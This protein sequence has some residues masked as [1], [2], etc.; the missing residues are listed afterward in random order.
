MIT[1]FTLHA[2]EKPLDRIDSV[3]SMPREVAALAKPAVLRGIVTYSEPIPRGAFVIEDESAGIYVS[4]NDPVWQGPQPSP[5]SLVE[6]TGVTGQGGY[7]PVLHARSLK[8]LGKAWMP[9]AQPVSVS[10]L[11]TGRFDSRRVEFRGVVRHAGHRKEMEKFWLEMTGEFGQLSV[12]AIE[13]GG[14][15]PEHLID[16][17][18]TVRG[19]C[20]PFFNERAQVAGVRLV[21]NSAREVEINRPPM[22]DPFEIPLVPLD[23]LQPFSPQG[24][25][26]HRQ[27]IE[28]TVTFVEPGSFL[29]LQEGENAVRV[30]LARHV[31][32]SIGDRV[33]AVG[34]PEVRKR[35]IE[36]HRA[37]VR[38]TG[39]AP[40][41][42]PIHIQRQDAVPDAPAG[43]PEKRRCLDGRL[44]S[45]DGR[46]ESV[47]LMRDGGMNLFLACDGKVVTAKVNP[48]PGAGPVDDLR[49]GSMVRAT[50]VCLVEYTV[51][52]P[53]RD[54]SN[55]YSMSLLIRNAGDVKVLSAASW[56]TSGRLRIALG[57]SAAVLVLAFA[58]VVALRREVTRKTAV[59]AV[60]MGA[61]RDAQVEF[62][63]TLRERERVA[64]D[65][66]DTV[67]QALTGSRNLSDV[68]A[69][70]AGQRHAGSGDPLHHRWHRSHA[71]HGRDLL[72]TH[73]HHFQHHA[74]GGRLRAGRRGKRGG[75]RVLSDRAEPH[76]RGRGIRG[77][78]R[79]TGHGP[80]ARKL[81]PLS[82]RRHYPQ[83]DRPLPGSGPQ[84][85]RSATDSNDTTDER[86][87][88][89]VHP[90][91][92]RSDR[93][94][95]LRG[96]GLDQER[97]TGGPRH[98]VRPQGHRLVPDQF[99]LH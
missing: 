59:L 15:E 48:S 9:V 60:E 17:E 93:R 12:F 23:K 55:P 73:R 64:V 28:G 95:G 97:E 37:L 87:S 74:Q 94:P 29:Y 14:V 81:A 50:G 49:A 88:S 24:I 91:A 38:K 46:L 42:A 54:Y 78:L 62:D 53:A 76:R 89:G 99:R 8:V 72:A 77:P 57:A 63:A 58:W 22:G 13:S 71:Q 43:Q 36:W 4:T 92:R 98:L 70:L 10:Q 82:H 40:V 16:A 35:F 20:F 41:P 66:H 75:Q 96:R 67:E 1:A 65:L 51:L 86:G 79:P 25:N 80:S 47:E 56:W 30:N 61:R 85:I 3:H 26:F 83:H 21:M 11:L 6:V 44:V 52:W 5:G 18:V 69:C 32:V 33:T 39:V 31:P 19:V 7:A 34:F 68:A 27:R 45:I 90:G 2:E 84:R